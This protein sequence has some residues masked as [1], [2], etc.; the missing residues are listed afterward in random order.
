MVHTAGFEDVRRHA[1]FNMRFS[2]SRRSVP[3][4]VIHARGPA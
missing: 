3:H 4:V 2:G 1:R